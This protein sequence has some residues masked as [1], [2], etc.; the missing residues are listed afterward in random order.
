MSARPDPIFLSG[1]T[2]GSTRIEHY[3]R[4]CPRLSSAHSVVEKSADVIPDGY[5]AKCQICA[6]GGDHV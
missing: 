6:D 1:A 2:S 5:F 4:D 3:D